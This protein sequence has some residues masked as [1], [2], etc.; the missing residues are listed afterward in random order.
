MDLESTFTSGLFLQV[1]HFIISD[2]VVNLVFILKLNAY[3]TVYVRNFQI[4]ASNYEPSS[5]YI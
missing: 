1:R 3:S 4:L 5:Y 2:L